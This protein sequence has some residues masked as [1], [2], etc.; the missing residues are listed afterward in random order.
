M[1]TVLNGRGKPVVLT[2]ENCTRD[3]Y[4]WGYGIGWD[5][6]EWEHAE[7]RPDSLLGAL[8]GCPDPHISVPHNNKVEMNTRHRI[9][10]KRWTIT[11]L[12]P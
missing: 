3:S 10:G 9:R 6:V 8:G 2:P 7:F 5:D 1:R 12:L 11:G 4:R